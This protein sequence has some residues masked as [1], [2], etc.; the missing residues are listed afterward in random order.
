MDLCCGIFGRL[1]GH[2]YEGRFSHSAPKVDPKMVNSL[3]FADDLLALNR[4]SRPVTYHGDVCVRCGHIANQ[5]TTPPP[6]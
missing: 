1:F 2:K 6:R 3:V 5:P 4:A